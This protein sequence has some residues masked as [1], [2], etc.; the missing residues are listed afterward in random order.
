MNFTNKRIEDC[1]TNPEEFLDYIAVQLGW[2]RLPEDLYYASQI[3]TSKERD[4]NHSFC[5]MWRY[6][7]ARTGFGFGMFVK[8]KGY[9]RRNIRVNLKMTVEELISWLRLQEKDLKNYIN[10]ERMKNMSEDF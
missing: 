5:A 1:L 4:D 9:V 8:G 6:T 10:E 3:T 7:S 2:I